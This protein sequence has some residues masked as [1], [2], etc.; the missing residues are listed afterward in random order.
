[1]SRACVESSQVPASPIE[2]GAILRTVTFNRALDALGTSDQARVAAKL[3]EFEKDWAHR[4]FEDLRQQWGLKPPRVDKPC[5]P[6]GLHQ[7]QPTSDTRAWMAP[8]PHKG[9]NR[10][11]LLQVVRKKSTAEENR[12]IKSLCKQLSQQRG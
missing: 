9:Q 10:W 1:M 7:F 8:D 12:I 5:R 3:G 4:P 6:N 11:L 2:R